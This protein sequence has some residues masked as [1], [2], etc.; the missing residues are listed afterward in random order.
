M[1]IHISCVFQSWY[2]KS[3][4]M[5]DAKHRGEILVEASEGN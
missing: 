5:V 1:N 4:F 2:R 3:P